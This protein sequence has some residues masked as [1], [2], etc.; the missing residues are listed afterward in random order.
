MKL[1]ESYMEERENILL[2]I[3]T[4]GFVIFLALT[5]IVPILLVSTIIILLSLL[6]FIEPKLEELG[7]IT[8]KSQVF[9]YFFFSIGIAL[10]IANGIQSGNIPI[11]SIGNAFISEVLTLTIY[12]LIIVLLVIIAL[13]YLERNKLKTYIKK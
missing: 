7:I 4:L 9:L 13:A 2:M 3:A 8:T 10:L 1:K 11:L 6:W 12:V 5:H